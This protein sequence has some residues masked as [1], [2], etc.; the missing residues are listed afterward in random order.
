M[1]QV[2]SKYKD[3][4]QMLKKS[5]KDLNLYG[6]I[7]LRT[8]EF[9][10]EFL[11]PYAE[12][13]QWLTGFT[14]SAGLAIVLQDRAVVMSDGRY[15]LQLKQQVDGDLFDTADSTVISIGGWLSQNA[16]GRIGYD[17]WLH[18]PKQIEKIIAD[19]GDADIE[20]VPINTNPVDALWIDQP[21]RPKAGITIFPDDIAGV[22]SFDKRH[23]TAKK[24]KEVGAASCLLT[25]SDSICWLLNV[26]GGDVDFSPLI[27]S[28]AILH[29]D[30]TLDWFVDPDKVGKNLVPTLGD[31]VRLHDFD[32][33]EKQ[34]RALSS[35]IWVDRFSA[36]IWFEQNCAGDIYDAPDPCSLPK[37][38]KTLSEKSAIKQAH[39]YDGVAIVKFL[40]WIDESVGRMSLNELSVEEK[41][42]EFRREHSSYLGASFSTIA[43]FNANGAI[44]HYRATESTNE[45]IEGDG[46]LLV[47]SGGQYQWGTTDITR[48]IAIGTP[49]QEMR[50]NYTRVL[51]GHI[52]LANA[53]FSRE[54]LAKDIDALA[55]AP[56]Q[57]VG[58]NY[59][60]GTGHGVGCYLCVHEESS[61]ISPRGE[62][63]FE[64]GMLIS[65]EPGYYEEGAYG[66]RTENLVLV[67]ECEGQLCF[68]TVTLAPFDC[69]LI[70]WDMLSEDET[71]WLREYY[72]LIKE[73]IAPLLNKEEKAWLNEN[74]VV[75]R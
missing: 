27:L 26:R 3:R 66:I 61:N 42:E 39:I 32:A 55:R 22:S 30:G 29:D 38:I 67:Q 10:G 49:S 12:R 14:G 25:L 51:Q 58:L 24:L 23:D 17:V 20:L 46:L 65:N 41:L 21:D 63:T 59:A 4:L 13:V 19:I 56:L 43:G 35:K 60:H 34:F 2:N 1:K 6:F 16:S 47:D 36:P 31:G 50:E 72:S 71:R 73:K 48:T 28:Y 45:A 74:L 69:R 68:E 75:H 11:A 64:A 8:D 9:Q 54:T 53:K 70:I 7:M 33:I 18:T 15:T 57:T 5:I 52:A 40:K 37:S 44:I 62:K